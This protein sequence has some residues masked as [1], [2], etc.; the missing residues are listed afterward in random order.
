[1]NPQGRP[2]GAS[3]AA[4]TARG[5]ATAAPGGGIGLFGGSFDP[6]HNGHLALATSALEHLKLEEVRWMPA[7]VPWQ[8]ADRELTP[9]EHRAAMVRLAILGERRFRIDESEVQREGPTYTIDTVDALL[10]ERPRTQIVLIVGQ[11]QYARLHTWYEWRALLSRVTLAVAGRDGMIGRA[12][13]ELLGV[14]HRV[15]LLPMPEMPISSSQLRQMVG[16]GEDIRALV[17]APVA[18][19][20]ELHGLY[21][22]GT[23]AN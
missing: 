16:R 12:A 20:I 22:Q 19:Y 14:W 17:P 6:V 8:K 3:L 13:P 2:K 23:P 21:Q 10:A 18:R 7:G 1:M 4:A 11:D 9:A 15:E 5:A